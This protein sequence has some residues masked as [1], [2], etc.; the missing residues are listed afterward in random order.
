MAAAPP[1]RN[2]AVAFNLVDVTDEAAP[3]VEAEAVEAAPRVDSSL[4]QCRFY[5]SE[6][7]EADELV[8]VNVRS[9]QPMGAYVS[10]LEYNNIEG[11][12]LMSELS[13]RRIRSVN[14]LIRVGKNEVVMVIRVDK[15]KGA[16]GRGHGG[17]PYGYT[18]PIAVAA[19]PPPALRTPPCTPPPR[20]RVGYIDLSKR[21]VAPED[22]AKCEDRYNKSKTVHSIMRHIAEKTG[23]PLI[24][25]YTKYGWPL[26]AK[27][28]HAY[29]AF[30]HAVS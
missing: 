30:R 14:K 19:P 7:P 23:A 24:E 1:S 25:L 3:A 5:E 27:Y 17:R 15:E 20:A 9:I 26:Y 18:P 6:F 11:M 10:L 21:R 29:D 12:I 16:R 4:L 8:V 13:R 2:K 28:G 22:I